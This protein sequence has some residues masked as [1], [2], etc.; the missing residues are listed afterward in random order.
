MSRPVSVNGRRRCA[1]T[2]TTRNDLVNELIGCLGLLV[3]EWPDVIAEV[4][5]SQAALESVSRSNLAATGGLAGEDGPRCAT[6][7]ELITDI[8]MDG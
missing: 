1:P 6:D 8:E 3:Q 2:F 4:D 5:V 7:I